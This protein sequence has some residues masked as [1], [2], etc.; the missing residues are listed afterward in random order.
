MAA[1]GIAAGLS[2]RSGAR[3]PE[4]PG[5]E[6][7][8]GVRFDLAQ[9][10]DEARRRGLEAEAAFLG[11]R[12]RGIAAGAVGVEVLCLPGKA[13][14]GAALAEIGRRPLELDRRRH[15]VL[16]PTVAA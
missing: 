8:Q 13:D 5:T 12:E 15:E 7:R 2:L 10:L 14:A 11:R 1:N 9:Q 16:P 4:R 6:A 3:A